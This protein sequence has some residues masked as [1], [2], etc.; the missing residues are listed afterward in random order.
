MAISDAAAMKGA[1]VFLVVIPAGN[2][3]LARCR[4]CRTGAICKQIPCGNDNQKNNGKK[5]KCRHFLT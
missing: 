4:K 5:Q 2:L 3:L 1:F